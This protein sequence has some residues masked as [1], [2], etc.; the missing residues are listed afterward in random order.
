[1]STYDGNIA[2]KCTWND[3]GFK[4]ICSQSAYDYD[5]SKNRVWCTKS[6][7]RHSQE[8]LPTKITRVTKE[9]FSL[10]GILDRPVFF[11]FNADQITSREIENNNRLSLFRHGLDEE[12]VTLNDHS[13]SD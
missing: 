11:P 4:G 8:P 3:A 9:F 12:M 5:V 10:N 6:P 1:M 2:F 7:C 13:S